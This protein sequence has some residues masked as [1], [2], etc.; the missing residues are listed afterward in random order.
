MERLPTYH[1]I[2]RFS[3]KCRADSSSIAFSSLLPSTI[4]SHACFDRISLANLCQQAIGG[5]VAGQWAPVRHDKTSDW[6]AAKQK[7]TKK[8]VFAIFRG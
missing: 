7:S 8:A 3:C 2:P 5:V 4:L 6:F 1:P